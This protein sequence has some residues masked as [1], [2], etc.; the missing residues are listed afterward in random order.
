VEARKQGDWERAL[1]LLRR[2]GSYFDPALVSYFRGAVW[3]EAGDPAISTA[4]T[5]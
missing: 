5:S 1:D 3:L 2:W 4:H